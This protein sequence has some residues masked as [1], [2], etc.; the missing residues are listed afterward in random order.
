MKMKEGS[1]AKDKVETRPVPQTIAT[2]KKLGFKE[3]REFETLEKELPQ[4]EQERDELTGQLSNPDLSFEK[5][6]QYSERIN[7]LNSLIDEKEMR[8]LELSE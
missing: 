6:Q 7:E 2:K 5:L 8:W 1:K 3:Q 4:L